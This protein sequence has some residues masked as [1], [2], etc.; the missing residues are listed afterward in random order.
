MLDYLKVEGIPV[1]GKDL[2]DVYPRKVYFFAE[3]GQVLVR[4]IK[5][6]HNTTIIDRESAYRMQLRQR[7][8]SGDVE[9]FDE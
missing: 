7:R 8:Q 2:L 6:L 4:K 3:T 1:V 5:N 9:L